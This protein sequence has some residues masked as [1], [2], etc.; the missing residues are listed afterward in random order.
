MSAAPVPRR[1]FI[2][3]ANGFIGRSLARRYRALGAEV[4]GIDFVADPEWGVVAADMLQPERWRHVVEGSE[5]AIHTAAL[6]SNTAA[7]QDAWQ[8]NV[9]GTHGVIEAVAAAGVK[10]LVHVSSVAVFGFDHVRDVDENEPLR[11][12]N[13][14][15]VDTKIL[16][17]YAVLQAH[18]NGRLPATVVRPGDVYGPGSRPWVLLPLEMIRAGRF[19]LPERGKGVFSPV[20]IEDLLDGIVLAASSDAAI[21][22]I[23]TLT[24]AEKPSCAEYFSFIA[25]MAGTSGVRTLSTPIANLISDLGGGVARV[26]G[27]QS[28]LGR[29]TVRMLSRRAGYSIAKARNL[30]GYE[31]RVS[32]EEG[33]KRVEQWL[34][35]TGAI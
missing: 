31:P 8:T 29:N 12:I 15:Y 35:D 27:R 18:A 32:L 20:Y 22:Q 17:E 16:G 14:P 5:L 30:L 23:F 26:L 25:R 7:M 21:G 33:M 6:L 3:G 11:T 28:E 4:C 9:L 10:R 2:T 34:R 19:L 24:S 13:H 1:V